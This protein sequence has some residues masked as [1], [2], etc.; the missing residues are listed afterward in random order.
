MSNIYDEVNKI[1]N[2]KV[3]LKNSKHNNTSNSSIY[4]EMLQLSNKNLKLKSSM[5]KTP[6]IEEK[7]DNLWVESTAPNVSENKSAQQITSNVVAKPDKYNSQWRA[8][9]EKTLGG[10]IGNFF[11]S[12]LPQAAGDLWDDIKEP[13]VGKSEKQLLTEAKL[14]PK[15]LVEDAKIQL[16]KE[17]PT[18]E[19]Y[20]LVKQTQDVIK[21]YGTDE[22]NIRAISED[23]TQLQKDLERAEKTYQASPIDATF[24]NIGAAGAGILGDV[25]GFTNM[26]G[27]DKIPV[28]KDINNALNTIAKTLVTL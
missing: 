11:K 10:E 6:T 17:D 3:K 15:L 25:A 26:L 13:F 24:A 27:A 8:A 28:I 16:A 1:A 5:P 7:M 21:K 20:A 22:S 19:D 12:T 23:T 4:D 2:G 9:P 18:R 14:S